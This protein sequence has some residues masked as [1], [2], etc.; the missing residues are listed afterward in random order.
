M[1]SFA[2]QR[3]TG[4]RRVILLADIAGAHHERLDGA[5]YPLG[6]V[7]SQIARE[8]RIITTCDYYDA[9]TADRP[10]RAAMTRDEA[11][12]IMGEETGAALDPECVELLRSA[13]A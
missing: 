7:R 1:F 4:I 9:L 8:T 12:S 11:L 5:G 10:Y 13:T 2:G 6:L 3:C